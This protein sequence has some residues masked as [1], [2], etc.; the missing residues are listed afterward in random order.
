[1]AVGRY[2][3]TKSIDD[4]VFEHSGCLIEFQLLF[5]VSLGAIR[6]D[7]FDSQRR[8]A[9]DPATFDLRLPLNGNEAD[10]RLR[11]V[12]L[13]QSVGEWLYE[14]FSGDRSVKEL[15]TEAAP[16]PPSEAGSRSG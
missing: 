12:F 13:V 1:M 14:E 16:S 2:D 15:D 5:V 8:W 4:P 11:A 10:V 3:T 7:Q 6:A 9:F